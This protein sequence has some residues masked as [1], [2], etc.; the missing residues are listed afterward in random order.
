M[1]METNETTSNVNFR[2]KKFLIGEIIT[3]YN[4]KRQKTGIKISTS[5]DVYRLVK[6]LFRDGEIDHREKVY[7]VFLSRRNEVL[8]WQLQGLG[9]ISGASC[10]LRITFQTALLC[11]ASSIILAHNHPS[12]NL[13]ASQSDIDLTRKAKQFG[14]LIGMEILDHII[15]TSN[16]YLSLADEGLMGT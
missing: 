9:G 11:N 15:I 3:T 16:S 14:K 7:A 4:K 5:R 1:T 8:G 12:G 10:D 2:L 13:T 6:R